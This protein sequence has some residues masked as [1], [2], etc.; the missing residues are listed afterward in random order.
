MR[1]TTA[2]RCY[3]FEQVERWRDRVHRRT[4]GRAVATKVKA[5]Q[6][7][8]EVGFCFAF[9]SENSELPC[10]WH[11]ACGARS[12]R[13]PRHTHHDPYISFVWEMKDLL[14][15]ER[16]VYY[17]KLL[18]RR[19]MFVSLEYLPDFC[20]LANRGS[21]R[22]EYMQEFLRG[23]L[24]TLAKSIMDALLDS[25]PQDTRSLKLATSHFMRTDKLLFEKAITELQTK[26]F[27]VKSSEVH[28]PFSFMWAPI[29]EMF[30]KQLRKASKIPPEKA[31]ARILDRYFR[32]QLIAS[33]TDIQRLFRWDR[34][35]V[36]QALGC[37][38]KAGVI[39]TDVVV[40]GEPQKY[41]CL[42]R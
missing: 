2:K 23:N 40:E 4:P 38:A 32:N 30:Q 16:K 20:A 14:P 13:V 9:K 36:Y 7:I 5:L 42:V 31:R 22:D 19:P 39:T 27:L 35:H 24:S 29:G 28:E 33:A 15:T 41:Y 18:L 12:P 26:L 37:L 21:A 25:S 3:T 6:F 17:G 1:L 10:L 34:Q 8:D 11:A